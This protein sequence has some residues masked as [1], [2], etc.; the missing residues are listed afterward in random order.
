MPWSMVPRVENNGELHMSNVAQSCTP[1]LR[2]IQ[3][4]SRQNGFLWERDIGTNHVPFLSSIVT[5]SF[6]H[7]IRNLQ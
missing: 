7:F 6:A 5:V 3:V 1:H 2:D 4:E